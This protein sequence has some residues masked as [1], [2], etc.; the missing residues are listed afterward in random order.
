MKPYRSVVLALRPAQ[1]GVAV[2]VEEA[3]QEG[4]PAQVDDARAG[5]APRLDLRARAH[6]Q[7]AAAA[8]GDRF[9]LRAAV[10]HGD[11][12]AAEIDGVGGARRVAR[13]LSGGA[14]EP[15]AEGAGAEPES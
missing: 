14:P 2:R 9:R 3:G 11:D 12:G 6:R 4:P 7:D 13:G 1:D 5:A 10:V 8:H 15:A